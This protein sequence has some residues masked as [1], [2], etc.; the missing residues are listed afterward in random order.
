MGPRDVAPL[1][2]LPLH[3]AHDM[4]GALASVTGALRLLL[5][6]VRGPLSPEQRELVALA[7]ASA[8]TLVNLV[9]VPSQA[10][11]VA[12]ARQIAHA[13]IL[14]VDDDENNRVLMREYLR[15]LDVDLSEAKSG[16][17]AL[18]MVRRDPPDLIILDMGL[19]DLDG[20]DVVEQI[21][22][23]SARETPLLIYSGRPLSHADRERLRLGPT[24]HL[25]KMVDDE[26]TLVA[27][28]RSLLTAAR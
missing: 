1:Q 11:E 15:D 23:G 9:D 22:Q 17:E 16:I 3:F 24:A 2:A 6:E 19:P 20:F 12:V 28:V 10:P 27:T 26:R 25:L 8:D 5:A 14:I 13:R 21:R 18:E 4:R 7:L